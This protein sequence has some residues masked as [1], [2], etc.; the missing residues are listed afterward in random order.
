MSDQEK[1]LTACAGL[2]LCSSSWSTFLESR[3]G[4]KFSQAFGYCVQS[5]SRLQHRSSRLQHRSNKSVV[6]SA[7][8]GLSHLVCTLAACIAGI[9]REAT[10]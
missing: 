1:T 10:L 8:A 6:E 4:R 9:T 3:I 5:S 2:M 7:F